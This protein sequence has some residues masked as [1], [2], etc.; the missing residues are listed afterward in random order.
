LVFYD[1]D[2]D[3]KAVFHVLISQMSQ[4]SHISPV[5]WGYDAIIPF[6]CSTRSCVDYVV[7]LLFEDE[8][9]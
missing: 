3:N 2:D 4:N 9:R 1:D 7:L 6:S 8:Q 5:I